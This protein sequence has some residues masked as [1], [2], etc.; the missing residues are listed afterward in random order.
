MSGEILTDPPGKMKKYLGSLQITRLVALVLGLLALRANAQP[1]IF[2]CTEAANPGDVIAIQGDSFG[3]SPQVWML[4]VTG[5]ETSLAPQE[6]LTILSGT[7]SLNATGSNS[8]VSALIPSG[9]TPGLYVIWVSADGGSTFSPGVYVNQAMPWNADD[10]CGSAVDPNRPF[11]L[12]GRNLQFPGYGTPSVN[13]VSTSGTLV[14]TV[15][16]GTDPYVL[17]VTSPAGVHGGVSYTLMVNKGFGGAYGND[18]G[19]VLSGTITGGNDPFGLGVPWGADFASYPGKV[20]N[21]AAPTGNGPTDTGNIQKAINAVSGSGG[22]IVALQAGTYQLSTG[23]AG[24]GN[25]FLIMKTNVVI[26]GAGMDQTVLLMTGTSTSDPIGYHFG[27]YDG[28]LTLID[29]GLADLTL[30]NTPTGGSSNL[31]FPHAAH[32]R[33]FAVNTDFIGDVSNNIVFSG[34][35]VVMKNCTIV[36]GTGASVVSGSTTVIDTGA[37]LIFYGATYAVVENSLF[38]YYAGRIS[39]AV[40]GASNVLVLSNTFSRI[41]YPTSLGETGALDTQQSQ[42]TVVLS[43]VLQRDPV[44]SGTLFEFEN[45]D[46]ETILNQTGHNFNS[47][48]GNVTS[49]TPTTLTDTTENWTNN[50]ANAVAIDGQMYYVTIIKGPGTG[51]IREVTGNTTTTLTIDSPW[52]VIPGVGSVYAVHHLESLR[53]LIK[54][55]T[56]NSETQGIV[57]YSISMKDTVIVNNT[58]YNN[59]GIYLR[60]D[61]RPGSIFSVQLDTLVAGNSVTV[62][63]TSPYNWTDSYAYVLDWLVNTGTGQAPGTNAFC[64]EFRDN[65]VTAPVPNKMSGLSGEGYILA[66]IVNGGYPIKDGTTVAAVGAIFQGN[67]A[68]SCSNAFHLCTGDYYTTIWGNGLVSSGSALWD[69]AGTGTGHASI[70]TIYGNPVTPPS[71]TSTLSA[72]GTSG[73]PFTY[74]IT[75]AN[76]PTRFAATELPQLP[77]GLGLNPYTGVIS[78]IPTAS[79][80]FAITISAINAGGTNS[81][82]LSLTILAPP[83]SITSGLTL[84]GTYGEPLSYQITA[85]NSPVSFNATGLP[86]GM[87]LDPSSGLISG[88]PGESGTF[89]VGLSAVG[90][91]GTSQVV[92]L[93]L[94]VDVIFGGVKGTYKGVVAVGGSD[95]GLYTLTLNGKGGFTGKLT[96]AGRQYSFKNV[97]TIDGLLSYT[98]KVGATLLQM[99]LGIEPGQAAV[100]GTIVATTAGVSTQ[101]NVGGSLLGVYKPAGLPSGIAGRYT[102]VLPAVS[103]SDPKLPQG[104]GYGTMTVSSRGAIRVT[105]KLGD[106][107]AFSAGSQLDA[108]GKTWMLFEPLYGGRTPGWIDGMMTFENIAGSDCDGTIGWSKPPRATARYYPGGFAVAVQMVAAK[109]VSPPLATGTASISIGG[110]DL[111]QGAVSDALMISTMPNKV[112]VSGSNSGNV[113]VALVPGTGMFRGGFF[114]PAMAGTRKIPFAG[115]IFQKPGP[116]AFGQF[117]GTDQSGSLEITR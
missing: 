41:A 19:P 23:T 63:S 50:Y 83:P 85:S 31:S 49:A 115:V 87:S 7:G 81:N 71:I 15:A 107:T 60:S 62:T 1:T 18:T 94:N 4:H 104:P 46:G 65:T 37:P 99:S 13:F 17:S 68:V 30:H 76:T 28:G 100:S 54:D 32:S 34:T 66:P 106:G 80:T 52:Q 105:G 51:Q 92:P 29:C 21:V 112:V 86:P 3:N 111:P 26:K 102:V 91:S 24:G 75:A 56:L 36:G 27:L 79:G 14:A 2:N 40:D 98:V 78:G 116:A 72:T 16:S 97:F 38:E 96:L 45:N 10:L 42:D 20:Y 6:Q 95:Q 58:L 90:L 101:Y 25:C 103:G 88:T 48:Q 109:Y 77:P 64:P 110:G 74:Q 82:T 8:F 39:P 12:Y 89:A 73:Y 57:Y 47:C 55:N 5:T 11:H 113:S 61:Y 22:G 67:T 108:D 53:H 117:L 35:Q 9:E 70:E 44:L 59:G 114:Y 33:F 84:T 93:V 69:Q 43:N